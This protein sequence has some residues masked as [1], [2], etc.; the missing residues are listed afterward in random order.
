MKCERCGKNEGEYLCSACNRVVCIDCKVIDEGKVYCLDHAPKKIVQ[1]ETKPKSFKTLKELIYADLILL[2]GV[3]I[4]FFISNSLISNFLAS[5][6]ETVF[7]YLPM[8]SPL[9]LLL[10]FFGST[11]MYLI[12]TLLIILILLII[13]FIIKKRRYKNI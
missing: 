7:E 9:F 2:I 4:I 8:I 10:G 5:I 13:V 3:I 6:E 11:S 1:K 12:I